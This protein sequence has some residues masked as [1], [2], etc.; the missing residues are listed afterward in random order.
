[1]SED[2]IPPWV[3]DGPR[4]PGRLQ[5][6][7]RPRLPDPGPPYR[8]MPPVR[9]LYPLD[10]RGWRRPSQLEAYA[11]LHA[12]RFLQAGEWLEGFKPQERR[13]LET[14]RNKLVSAQAAAET[15]SIPDGMLARRSDMPG[16]FDAPAAPTVGAVKRKRRDWSY[17]WKP[18]ETAAPGKR[19]KKARDRYISGTRERQGL[20]E[21]RQAR[22]ARRAA[23]F[24]KVA[25]PSPS[26]EPSAQ[27]KRYPEVSPPA[28]KSLD[29]SIRE[30]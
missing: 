15:K 6:P 30:C 19:A 7:K 1:M 18:F 11:I 10:M 3:T 23:K 26:L 14:L 8:D 17:R 9:Q 27:P 22:E 29:P 4:L 28:A 16:I 2:E 21:R 5:R 24:N 12:I 20:L 25:A 13:A